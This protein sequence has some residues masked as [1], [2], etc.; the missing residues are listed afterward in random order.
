[1]H[2]CHSHG[3]RSVFRDRMLYGFT[4]LSLNGE[5]DGLQLSALNSR[6]SHLKLPEGLLNV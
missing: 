6:E 5:D 4:R 1:M 2:C 3:V